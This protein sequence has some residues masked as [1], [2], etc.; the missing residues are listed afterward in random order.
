MEQERGV[1]E[2]SE[3]EME[4][5]EEE[6]YPGKGERVE[7]WVMNGRREVMKNLEKEMTAIEAV[8]LLDRMEQERMEEA[9]REEARREEETREEERR[10]EKMREEERSEEERSEEERREESRRE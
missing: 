1:E 5:D 6:E 4:W 2:T 10:K 3:V 7:Q 8:E 9:R